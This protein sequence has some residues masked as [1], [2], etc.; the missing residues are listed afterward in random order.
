MEKYLLIFEQIL[1]REI[2][3]GELFPKEQVRDR[4]ETILN[5]KIQDEELLEQPIKE[6][7]EYIYNLLNRRE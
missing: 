1:G 3:D 7:N 4:L 5:R 2:K 6:Y